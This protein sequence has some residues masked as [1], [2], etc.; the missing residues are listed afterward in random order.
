LAL[1]L[2][3]DA[4]LDAFTGGVMKVA[5]PVGESVATGIPKRRPMKES[6]RKWTK[7]VME[8]GYTIVPSALMEMQH[9]LSLDSVDLNIIMQLATHWWK[10]GRPPYLSKKTLAKRMGLTPSTVRRRIK[11]LEKDGLLKRKIRSGSH[12]GRLANEYDLKPLIEKLHP[13]AIKLK[14]AR[15]AK[16]RRREAEND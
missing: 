9:E 13:V 8:P 4:Q 10:S 1:I 7:T 16:R 3:A 6:I 14:K 12:N 15:D 5:E 2:D 11:R